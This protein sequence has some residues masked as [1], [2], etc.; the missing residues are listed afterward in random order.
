MQ[1]SHRCG[2]TVEPEST[3]ADCHDG[4]GW[5]RGR[6]G[7][8]SAINGVSERCLT[9]RHRR[10]HR[11]TNRHNML[12][13]ERTRPGDRSVEV[14]DLAQSQTAG[15]ARFAVPAVVDSHHSEAPIQG[16]HDARIVVL[17][18]ETRESMS[19]DQHWIVGTTRGCWQVRSTDLNPVSGGQSIVHPGGLGDA[20]RGVLHSQLSCH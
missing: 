4:I 11:E 5:V 3:A 1:Q 18:A 15:T 8:C 12:M 16:G 10:T 6:Q 13:A 2:A 17:G 14:E 20:G 19:H 7:Q 9:N